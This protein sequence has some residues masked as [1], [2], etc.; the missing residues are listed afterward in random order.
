MS[1]GPKSRDSEAILVELLGGLQ[2]LQELHKNVHWT[3]HGESFY[4]DHLLY[5][6][7]YENLDSEIDALA[8]KIVA[9]FDEEA[10]EPVRL[11]E[12]TQRY[13]VQWRTASECVVEQSLIAE[14]ELQDMISRT[15]DLISGQQ[16][17]SL[18]LDDFLMA[19]ANDHETHIYLIQQKVRCDCDAE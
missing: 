12:Y 2:A 8:E 1:S 10:V 3:A 16:E 9:Y 19:M 14:R 7:L 17:M 6:R 13:V 4:G 5:Q 11:L 18:G 15:Y